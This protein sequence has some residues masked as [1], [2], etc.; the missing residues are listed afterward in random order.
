MVTIN[1]VSLLPRDEVLLSFF[2]DGEKAEV[3]GSDFKLPAPR[4]IT[5]LE[6]NSFTLLCCHWG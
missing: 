1:N 2:L 3:P 4:D 5:T 6:I